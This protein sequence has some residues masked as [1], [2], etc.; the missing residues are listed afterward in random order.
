MFENRVNRNLRN[1]IRETAIHLC[2]ILAHAVQPSM[3]PFRRMVTAKFPGRI[4]ASIG[5]L[6]APF[7]L[8]ASVTTNLVAHKQLVEQ[9]GGSSATI[10]TWLAFESA[11]PGDIIRY[12]IACRNEGNDP[13]T[14]IQVHLPIPAEMTL[15]LGSEASDGVSVTYSVDEGQTFHA[16]SKLS[17]TTPSGAVRSAIIDDL[18]A[19]RWTLEKPL[20]TGTEDQVQCLLKLR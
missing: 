7:T 2:G 9:I 12:T 16:F 19:L 11:L 6:F 5:L 18:N 14:N 17:V 20:P 4:L 15:V 13:A 8:D 1:P 10:T 3:A